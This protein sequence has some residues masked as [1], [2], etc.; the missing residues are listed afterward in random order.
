MIFMFKIT[1]EMCGLELNET[2]GVFLT[3]RQQG[4][5]VPLNVCRECSAVVRGYIEGALHPDEARNARYCMAC[6]LRARSVGEPD[7]AC[8]YK[9][10]GKCVDCSMW[11]L[12][13]KVRENDGD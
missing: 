10:K 13:E 9:T 12:L 8:W 6:N 4:A 11:E 2:G 7:G 5:V 1:C 3:V